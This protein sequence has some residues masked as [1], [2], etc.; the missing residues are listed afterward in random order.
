MRHLLVICIICIAHP[1]KGANLYVQAHLNTSS[2]NKYSKFDIF[3]FIKKY[4]RKNT[5]QLPF[6]PYESENNQIE[7]KLAVKRITKFG[8]TIIADYIKK[9]IK[10]FTYK[11]K[12]RSIIIQQDTNH[13]TD[14]KNSITKI[15]NENKAEDQFA[16]TISCRLKGRKVEFHFLNN[17]FNLKGTFRFNGHSQIDFNKRFQ[18]FNFHSTYSIFPKDGSHTLKLHKQLFSNISANTSFKHYYFKKDPSSFNDGIFEILYNTS[19]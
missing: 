16:Y 9:K 14:Q 19:F 13:K 2:Q 1:S 5:F 8:N 4:D 6:D 11:S 18:T 3:S 15:K 7:K 17:H 12:K 10:I